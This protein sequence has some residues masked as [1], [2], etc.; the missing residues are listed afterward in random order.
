MEPDESLVLVVG[1]D[2]EPVENII[3]KQGD[4]AIPTADA[5]RPDVA[6]LLELKGWMAWVPLPQLIDL[7]RP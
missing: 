4:G 2:P 3:L 5:D 6:R 1:S 7:P